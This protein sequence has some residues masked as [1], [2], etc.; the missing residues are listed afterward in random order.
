MK[1]TLL[2]LATLSLTSLVGAGVG[3]GSWLVLAEH[4]TKMYSNTK[5]RTLESMKPVTKETP[6]E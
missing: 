2:S 5:C 6:R 4:E 3:V 1:H